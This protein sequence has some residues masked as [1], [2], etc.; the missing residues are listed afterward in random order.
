[1]F[2][3]LSHVP[4]HP[5]LSGSSIWHVFSLALRPVEWTFPLMICPW[6]GGSEE[7]WC[8][9]CC[10]WS[11]PPRNDRC[12]FSSSS[13]RGKSQ[14]HV[15]SEGGREVQSHNLIQE[16]L[17]MLVNRLVTAIL[18]NDALLS[19]QFVNV[20]ALRDSNPCLLARDQIS[21]SKL[22]IDL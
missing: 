2:L 22:I 8:V 7:A 21:P 20:C 4:F 5:G 17:R 12:Y 19:I 9:V 16:E 11:I 3:C 15:S 1:M 18:P 14:G 13:G 6:G 10:F